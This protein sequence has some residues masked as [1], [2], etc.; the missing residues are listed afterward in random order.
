[1]HVDLSESIP[2]N[3]PVLYSFASPR[4]GDVK[5]ARNFEKIE[6]YRIANSEDIVPKIPLPSLLLS[7]KKLAKLNYQHI[8]IPIY[9]TLQ[10]GNIADN[11]ILP[12]Y[13]Q[14]VESKS[15]IAVPA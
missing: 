5:F 14:S 13:F 12:A 4:V 11:H 8:G 3:S 6:C 7:P 15:D 10:K 9:F 2:C 1:L